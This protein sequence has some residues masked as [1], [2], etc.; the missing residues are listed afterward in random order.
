[1]HN[2]GMPDRCSTPSQPLLRELARRSGLSQSEMAL[3]LNVSQS[4]ISRLL[5]GQAT[6]VTP[7]MHRLCEF[8]MGSLSGTSVDRVRENRELLE[9]IAFAWDGSPRHAEA[10]ATVIRSLRVLAPPDPTHATRE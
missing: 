9:A 6:R 5:S 3:A 7:L 10:L 8:L 1:M 4:Q 2:L